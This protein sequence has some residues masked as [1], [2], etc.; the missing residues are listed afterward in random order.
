MMARPFAA[1]ILSEGGPRET[2][3]FF[4]GKRLQG[5]GA[6]SQ[7]EAQAGAAFLGT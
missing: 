5:S 2:R 6:P 3:R 7:Q 1:S 4:L